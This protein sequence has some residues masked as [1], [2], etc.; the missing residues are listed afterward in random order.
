MGTAGMAKPRGPVWRPGTVEP[1]G[2]VPIVKPCG[3]VCCA[4]GRGAA[5]AGG[6]VLAI[7]DCGMPREGVGAGGLRADGTGLATAFMRTGVAEN[8][9]ADSRAA[10]A[11]GPSPESR[12][13][14]GV[15]GD[16]VG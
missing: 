4:G 11:A 3:A 16:G 14:S 10:E 13:G 5:G 6:R 2:G 9:R 8:P 7:G 15:V 1:G 12:G